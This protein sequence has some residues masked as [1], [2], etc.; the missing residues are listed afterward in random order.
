MRIDGQ[1]TM[2]K[3]LETLSL[4]FFSHSSLLLATAHV[5]ESQSGTCVEAQGH[6]DQREGNP[7]RVSR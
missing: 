7:C 1:G 3:H 6:H 5:D 2:G 4:P